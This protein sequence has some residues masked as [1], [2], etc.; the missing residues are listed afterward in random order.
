MESSQKKE[1][2]K[3]RAYIKLMRQDF[4]KEASKMKALQSM[5]ETRLIQ[6][7]LNAAAAT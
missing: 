3:A 6:S 2:R 4:S 1:E 7:S 5:K